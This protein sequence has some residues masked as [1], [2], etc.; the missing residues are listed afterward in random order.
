ML[1]RSAE[2]AFDANEAT[3]DTTAV[4]LAIEEQKEAEATL[5]GA[6]EVTGVTA[7]SRAGH[8]ITR[9]SASID[10]GL[11]EILQKFAIVAG[12]ILKL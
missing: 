3:D 2:A 7:I 1:F 12:P 5:A 9:V 4:D 8:V 10:G 11:P 6:M